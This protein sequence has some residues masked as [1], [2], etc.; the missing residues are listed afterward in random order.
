MSITIKTSGE[1][2]NVALTL[3]LVAACATNLIL[4]CWQL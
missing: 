4:V 1:G 3:T 2:I